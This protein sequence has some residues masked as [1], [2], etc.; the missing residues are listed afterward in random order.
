VEGNYFHNNVGF[1]F[2]APHTAFPTNVQV[3]DN[4]YVSDWNSCLG[5]NPS[6]GEDN[7]AGYEVRNHVELYHDFGIGGYDGGETTFRNATIAFATSGA[8]YKTFRRG[9]NS[10][11]WC[12]GCYFYKVNHPNFPGGSCMWEMKDTI[13]D[14]LVTNIN[15]NHHCGLDGEWTGG[16]CA[17]HFWFTGSSEVRGGE[18]RIGNEAET[19]SDSIVYLNGF[20]HFS[21]HAAHPAFNSNDCTQVSWNAPPGNGDWTVCSTSNIRIVRIYSPD[22]GVITVVNNNESH[23]YDVP[24]TPWTKSSGW[25]R[26]NEYDV[27]TDYQNAGKGYTFLVKVGQSYTLHVG[28]SATLPDLFTLEY[29][30]H[31]MPQDSIRLAVVSE[32]R[33]AGDSC[34][35]PSTHSRNWITPYGPYVPASGAWWECRNNAGQPW[36]VGYTVAQ[37]DEAQQVHLAD[38]NCQNTA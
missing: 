33:I 29:S 3:N 32:G 9:R 19:Y 37:H 7:S 20:T 6:T 36:S 23:S 5:F 13:F 15:I 11:P 2:Y 38:N 21:T 34:E 30:D 26:P 27:R 25:A 35:I 31:H 17:S 8:Y 16:L 1:G 24:Y 18:L 14:E 12:D 10:G 4:G 28:N 22:R